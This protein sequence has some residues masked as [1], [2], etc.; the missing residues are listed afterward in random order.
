MSTGPLE[1]HRGEG[2]APSSFAKTMPIVHAETA[3]RY[4]AISAGMLL[5]G[6]QTEA[7]LLPDQQMGSHTRSAPIDMRADRDRQ[8]APH[9][10]RC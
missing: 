3:D 2:A 5:I 8:S 10:Q 9:Q 1:V 6:Q 4:L 7:H